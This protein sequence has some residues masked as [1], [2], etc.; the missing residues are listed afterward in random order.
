MKTLVL[1]LGLSAAS[2]L[3]MTIIDFVIGSKAEFLNAY[4]VFQ[5]MIGQTPS[6]GDSLVAQRLG[7]LGELGVV[8]AANLA[9]GGILTLLVRLFIRS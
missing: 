6:P 7:A 1:F 5:R 3:A 8:L 9:L 2:L 4:S